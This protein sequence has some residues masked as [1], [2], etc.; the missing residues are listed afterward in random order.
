MGTDDTRTSVSELREIVRQF[1]EER[2]WRRFHNAKNLSMSLSIEAAELMEHFQWLTT[3]E[4][5]EAGSYNKSAVA[6]ELADVIC[7]AVALANAL[8]ID[9]SQA[10]RGKMVKNRQKYPVE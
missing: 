2:N 8:E 9:I 3:D 5:L 10:V 1:V 4:V 6:A 7:Y